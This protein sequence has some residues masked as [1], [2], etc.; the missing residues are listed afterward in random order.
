M[1]LFLI[2]HICN[3]FRYEFYYRLRISYLQNLIDVQFCFVLLQP[4]FTP[5]LLFFSNFFQLVSI[6]FFNFFSDIV[7]LVLS[8][9]NSTICILL[10]IECLLVCQRSSCIQIHILV[11][12]LLQSNLIVCLLVFAMIYIY[13][14]LIALSYFLINN[15]AVR[16]H[17]LINH[18]WLWHWLRSFSGLTHI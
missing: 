8:T 14:N 7:D 16:I 18:D 3:N 2:T 1:S 5:I 11:V 4:F 10:L 15:H 9:Y 6:K 12:N 13:H 17:R